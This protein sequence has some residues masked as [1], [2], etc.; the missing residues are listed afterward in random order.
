MC[1]EAIFQKKNVNFKNLKKNTNSA[2]F[3]PM[4]KIS[5]PKKKYF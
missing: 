5:A 3:S 1:F 4:K 2:K